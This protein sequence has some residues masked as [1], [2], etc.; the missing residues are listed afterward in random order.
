[1]KSLDKTWKIIYILLGIGK[2]FLV[3]ERS[4]E[5]SDHTGNFPFL[6]Q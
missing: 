6:Q 4:G 1:M 5:R 2:W 3:L